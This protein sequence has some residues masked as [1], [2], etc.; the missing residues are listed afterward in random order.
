MMEGAAPLVAVRRGGHVESMHWGWGV[1][2]QAD[3]QVRQRWGGPVKTYARST[4]KPMQCLPL[5]R[6]G[7]ADHFQ[8]S[9][10]L[11]ALCAS[12]HAGEPFHVEG[13]LSLLAGIGL[14]EDA[15][16]CG[17]HPPLNAE[18]AEALREH[19]LSPRTVHHNCSGKHSGML[20]LAAHQGWAQN[21]YLGIAHP[22][23]KMIKQA[24]GDLTGAA[25]D[26]WA[27]DGCGAPIWHFSLEA[28][29]YGYARLEEDPA[30]TRIVAAMA[31]NPEYVAGTDRLD[32]V[33]MNA[34]GGRIIAKSGG[35]GIHA[36][37]IRG[38]GIGWAVKISDGNRRALPP[39]VLGILESQGVDLALQDLS[40]PLRY[41][42]RDEVI[43]SM[44]WLG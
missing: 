7:A 27:P 6:S 40:N 3:G 25:M 33:L 41:N 1:V 34:A 8:L 44:E 13:I 37:L 21:G 17:T 42:H 24:I 2:V 43:G 12:S 11:L 36:G 15:L 26:N 16:E 23:Q 39:A 19:G 18:A 29:A 4:L 9:P 20:M 5:V 38:K 35:E 22:V 31:E 14:T 10:K 30:G 32:T 28:L